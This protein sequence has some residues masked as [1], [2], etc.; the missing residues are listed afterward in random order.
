LVA[1]G[2]TICRGLADGNTYGDAIEIITGNRADVT[3]AQA[4]TFVR[5]AVTN[6]CPQYESLLPG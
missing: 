6:L 5:S 2:N 3:Q 1:L 4:D